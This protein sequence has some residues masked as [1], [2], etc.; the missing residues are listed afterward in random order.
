MT[1][2]VLALVLQAAGPAAP[3]TPPAPPPRLAPA[4]PRGGAALK[5]MGMSDAGIKVLQTVGAPDPDTKAFADRHAALLAKLGA[6]ADA[7]PFD[8]A[9]FVVAMKDEN[10]AEI[11]ARQRKIDVIT[12]TLQALPPADRQIYVRAVIGHR[13][14]LPPPPAAA[15][16]P[17]PAK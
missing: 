2:A 14:P 1:I 16:A 11:E 8:P 12:R 10:T 7:Q 9:A 5:A 3:V 17:P 6:V 15:P 4:P 13:D